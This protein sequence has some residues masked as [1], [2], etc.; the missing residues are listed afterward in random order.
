MPDP[1]SRKRRRLKLRNTFFK[2]W[3]EHHRFACS[4]SYATATSQCGAD[5]VQSNFGVQVEHVITRVWLRF[6]ISV[7]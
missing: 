5:P 4:I 1:L 2:S 7:Q 3:L 6:D